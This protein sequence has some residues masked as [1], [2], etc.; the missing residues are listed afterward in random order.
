MKSISA[1]AS[2]STSS[3]RLGNYFNARIIF[4]SLANAT[5]LRYNI[6]VR[7]TKISAELNKILASS[8]KPLTVL[9]ILALL[10]K[11]GLRPNKT[12]IYRQIEKMAERG[13]LEKVQLENRGTGYELKRG[14]HHHLVCNNCEKVED[15]VLKN[16]PLLEEKI[17]NQTNGFKIM[18]HTL[19]FYG[20]CRSC[21]VSK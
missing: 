9:G 14:H 12:T 18:N 13:E 1:L 2:F 19:E 20:L 17:M 6:R 16:E 21:V 15:V 7:Q 4:C 8:A 10:K 11:I 5:E 3:L